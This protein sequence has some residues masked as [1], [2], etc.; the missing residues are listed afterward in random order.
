MTGRLPGRV[1]V[2]GAGIAGLVVGWELARNGHRPLLLEAGAT[3]GGVLSAHMVGALQ[4]DAGAESFATAR[5]SV[6]EL[7]DELGLRAQVVTP[8]PVGAWVRHRSGSA[9]LPTG[10]LLGIPGRPWAA[11]VR[12]VIG[13]IGSAR[14][15]LDLALPRTSVDRSPGPLGA[16]VRVQDGRRVLDRLVEPVAGGVYA[17]DPDQLEIHTVAPGL[18]ALLAGTRS[19][20]GAV[21]RLRGDSPRPGSAVASLAGGMYTLAAG[22]ASAITGAGGA[23]RTATTVSRIEA[24]APPSTGWT[25]VLAGG[26]PITAHRLVIATPGPTAERLLIGLRDLPE[27]GVLHPPATEVLL[28]TLVVD[29]PR[30]DRAPRGTGVLVASAA[31]GV[32]AKAL[33]HAT[34]KWAW[35]AAAAGP[36]RHV[37]RLSYGRADGTD[38]PAEGDLPGI[39]L[40]DASTLLGVPLPASA[41]RAAAVVRWSSALPVPAPGHAA[42]V[43]ALRTALAPRGIEIVGSAVAGTGLTAVV[44]DARKAADGLHGALLERP[45]T[46]QPGR[47]DVLAA[48]P[49]TEPAGD[50]GGWGH[51]RASH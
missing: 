34:A 24:A 22:L 25:V 28:C 50:E 30:L 32:R 3:V 36:A 18:S 45:Q 51:D 44:A 4:L 38:L 12:R 48:S 49:G 47:A 13:P 31:T 10:S 33:T 41:V 16:L 5:P 46:S 6:T 17:A 43:A 14:A 11:D 2:I 19:L 27:P 9:P 7:I 15:C 39:A 26:P 37:L 21:R 29:D 20:S 8:N 42:K 23:I 1:V 40:A 35:L